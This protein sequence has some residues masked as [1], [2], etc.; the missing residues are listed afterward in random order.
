[1]HSY[2]PCSVGPGVGADEVCVG[3]AVGAEELGDAVG[4]AVVG[5]DVVCVG[6]AVGSIVV[7]LNVGIVGV[8][9]AVVGED[10]GSEVDEGEVVG[11]GVS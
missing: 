2:S 4:A 6:D 8:D 5:V 10:V 7:G 3:D 1:M 9:V 11:D